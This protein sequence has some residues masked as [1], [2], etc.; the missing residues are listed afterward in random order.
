MKAICR[1]LLLSSLLVVGMAAQA[2]PPN[3]TG[4]S[5]DDMIR[6]RTFTALGSRAEQETPVFDT[7]AGRGSRTP[8]DWHVLTVQYDV[9][10]EWID[11]MIVQFFL[12]SRVQDRQTGENAYSLFRKTVAYQDI[13][14]GRTRYAKAYLRPAGLKRFG[15]VVAAAAILS[16]GGTV[17][18]IP[19]E[20]SMDLPENWWENPLVLDNPSLT[21][22][23][24]YLLDRTETPW[25]FV[26][27]D[28]HEYIR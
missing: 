12:L 3:E 14:Q 24:G 5:P 10:A 9:R 8:Q 22:R 25:A 21:V 28:D 4:P 7:S 18:A 19:N 23:E 15:R 2:Q 20:T 1:H 6:L 11:E 17:V 13:E 27:F 16:I 26:H